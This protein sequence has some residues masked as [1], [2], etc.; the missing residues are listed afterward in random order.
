MEDR[1]S[2]AAEDLV[3][4]AC[5]DLKVKS[6]SEATK[7]TVQ[8]INEV[9]AKTQLVADNVDGLKVSVDHGLNTVNQNLLDLKNDIKKLDDSIEKSNKRRALEFPLNNTDYGSFSYHYRSQNGYRQSGSSRDLVKTILFCFR[10]GLGY[11]LPNEAT[12]ASDGYRSVDETEMKAFRD[13]LLKQV[14]DLTG[15]KPRI[16]LDNNRYI[17]YYS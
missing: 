16:V 12:L 11:Y 5:L 8:A 6:D 13:A 10:R 1:L 3:R 2:K 14:E 7:Q 17:I 15:T 4:A 9:S